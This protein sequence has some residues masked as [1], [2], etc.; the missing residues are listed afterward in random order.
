MIYFVME[1]KENNVLKRICVI[2]CYRFIQFFADGWVFYKSNCKNQ[3]FYAFFYAYESSYY[4]H[5]F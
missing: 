1:D 3:T 4:A 2:A 5:A